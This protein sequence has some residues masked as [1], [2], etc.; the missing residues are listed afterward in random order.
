M[1][2]EVGFAAQEGFFEFFGEETFSALL[3]EGPLGALVARSDDAEQLDLNAERGAQ[4]RGD[5]FRLREGKRTFASG[6]GEFGFQSA[7]IQ[8]TRI[9]NKKGRGT[10]ANGLLHG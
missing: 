7:G 6:E 1:D 9:K 8:R 3:F 2:R 10:N 5:L 4:V